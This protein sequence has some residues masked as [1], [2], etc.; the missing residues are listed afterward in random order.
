M[1]F[2]QVLEHAAAAERIASRSFSDK[3]VTE[4]ALSEMKLSRAQFAS[5]MKTLGTQAGPPWRSDEKAAATAAWI[6]LH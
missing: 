3:A 2:R 4:C 6:A 5:H 1:L